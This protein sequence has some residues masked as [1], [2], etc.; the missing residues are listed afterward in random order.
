MA[1]DDLKA[2]LAAILVE[3]E[4]VEIDWDRIELLSERAYVRLVT[5]P[6]T[7]LKCPYEEVVDYLASFRRR[8]ADADFGNEQREWLRAYL[9]SAS[10]GASPRPAA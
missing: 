5:M 6:D 1:I 9:G 8:Q 2:A 10:P 4:R 3:E 7:L